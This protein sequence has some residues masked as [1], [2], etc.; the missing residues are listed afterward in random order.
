MSRRKYVAPLC[1]PLHGR[2]PFGNAPN[3]R[4]YG[5]STL[6]CSPS[7]ATFVD[8][9]FSLLATLIDQI[10]LPVNDFCQVPDQ[11]NPSFLTAFVRKFGFLPDQRTQGHRRAFDV[12]RETTAV[13]L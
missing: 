8:Q 7:A 3:I 13:S 12:L 10:G 1:F 11:K 9:L 2:E 5:W 6:Y 4:N